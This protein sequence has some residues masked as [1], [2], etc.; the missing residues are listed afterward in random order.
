MNIVCK[1]SH[2]YI[3]S[4]SALDTKLLSKEASVIGGEVCPAGGRITALLFDCLKSIR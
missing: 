2:S 4:S 3:F 1:N